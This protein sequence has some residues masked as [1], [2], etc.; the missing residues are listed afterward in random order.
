MPNSS[1][2]HSS[3]AAASASRSGSGVSGSGI[4]GDG[5]RGD[6]PYRD[7]AVVRESLAPQTEPC[8]EPGA[9]VLQ[10]DPGGELDE[11]RITQVGP[12]TGGQLLGDLSGAARRRLG[13][14]EHH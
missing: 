3:N 14:L 4:S 12:E 11:L 9:E 2:R 6:V 1:E 8:V 5:I 13:V 10:R 7:L